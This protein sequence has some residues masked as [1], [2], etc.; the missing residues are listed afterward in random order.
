M[1]KATPLKAN[2]SHKILL[3]DD[4]A[5]VRDILKRILENEGFICQEADSAD[6]AL[7]LLEA[8]EF[9]LVLL[10]IQM[11][12]QSGLQLLPVL[13]E[14]FQDLAVIMATVEDDR[15]VA[16]QAL[17]D[18][19][20][21]YVIKPFHRNEI[22]INVMA[23]LER[24]RLNRASREH[25]ALLES[26]VCARTAE[27]S[28]LAALQRLAIDISIR[29][30]SL[31]PHQ[32]AAG[33]EQALADIT[34]SLGADRG[35]L[36]E[37]SPNDQG[38]TIT[39]EW[40]TAGIP[41]RPAIPQEDM[42]DTKMPWLARRLRGG[43]VIYL[44]SMEQL[45][46]E[47]QLERDYFSQPPMLTLVVIPLLLQQQLT[48]LIGFETVHQ[49]SNWPGE[50]ITLLELIG[51]IFVNSLARQRLERERGAMHA[52]LIQS[53]KLAAI[54]QLAAGV[55]HE[56]NTPI[57]FITSNL[58]SLQK[59]T[60]RLVDF[61]QL[62]ATAMEQLNDAK[63]TAQLAADR[64]NNKIDYITN[65]IQE[66]IQ[67]S[68]DGANKVKDIV[69]DL[70]DFS[71]ADEKIPVLADINT[72]LE[73]TLT[74]VRNELKYKATV[75]REFSELPDF[76]CFPQKLGQA[77]ANLLVNA[78]QA[79]ENQGE[80]IVRTWQENGSILVTITDT[81]SGIAEENL[82][83]IFDPFFTTKEVGQGTGLGLSI[84]Y[85]I[86]TKAHHGEITVTSELGQGTTF[87]VRLP[88]RPPRTS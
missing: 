86:I 75:Q 12:G 87:T 37:F 27:L 77:F 70:K 55:A 81:G 44:P 65:D 10:D 60:Q 23:A 49:A 71:R 13:S 88:L 83:K 59:Y 1:T 6:R 31:M 54:G 5:P 28:R 43:E 3:V 61:V 38:V 32:W 72:C 24:R 62:Q 11:P 7:E 20:Y 29:F 80:I 39:H 17:K 74:L 48:G 33:V 36:I 19:A 9:S 51:N 2:K 66:L 22:I 16:E 45:P 30:I 53:E 14:R 68:M 34:T 79:I 64:K 8:E 78:A 25:E 84:T 82:I 40:R 47:A 76:L 35:Y 69:K 46:P 21:G 15:K 73:N 67:E 4:E 26:R 85:D 57:G 18:G 42:L 50:I 41:S 52:Q 56:I 63:I 58:G